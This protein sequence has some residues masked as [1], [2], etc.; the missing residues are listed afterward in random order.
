MNM[1]LPLD[2]KRDELTATQVTVKTIEQVIG[3][4]Q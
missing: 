2:V 1:E 3:N 4:L